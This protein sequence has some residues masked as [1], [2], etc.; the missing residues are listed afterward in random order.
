VHVDPASLHMKLLKAKEAD[1]VARYARGELLAALS[2]EVRKS[3][4]NIIGIADAA[5]ATEL[6]AKQCRDL[7]AIKHA[8]TSMRGIIADALNYIKTEED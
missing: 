2:L 7:S 4:D 1:D 3:I 5:L 6:N 8:A